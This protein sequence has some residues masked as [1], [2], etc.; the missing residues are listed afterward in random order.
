MVT[1][2]A[3]SPVVL[4]W[5]EERSCAAGDIWQRLRYFW[6]SLLGADAAGI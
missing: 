6:S 5:W 1:F 4:S 2:L 3:F